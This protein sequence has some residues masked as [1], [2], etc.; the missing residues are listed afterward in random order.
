MQFVEDYEPTCADSYRKKMVFNGKECS[1][2]I[3]D[4][5]AQELASYSVIRDNYIRSADGYLCVFSLV[6]RETFVAAREF[7]DLILQVKMDKQFPC[8]LVGTHLDEENH[9]EVQ[10]NEADDLAASWGVTYIET[11]VKSGENVDLVFYSILK[12]MVQRKLNPSN[13]TSA[14]GNQPSAAGKCHG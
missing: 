3:T 12:L 10:R 9:R 2:D 1:I 7:R 4:V 8:M 14:T 5:T 13:Q 6:D 11:S